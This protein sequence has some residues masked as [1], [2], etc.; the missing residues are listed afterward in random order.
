MLKHINCLEQCLRLI[1]IIF[2]FV[3]LLIGLQVYVLSFLP[4]EWIH[5]NLK[6]VLKS[7]NM[8][9]FPILMING[10][11]GVFG[12]LFRNTA[13][14][15][16]YMT[17]SLFSA[18]LHLRIFIFDYETNELNDLTTSVSILSLVTIGVCA[19]GFIN[20][21]MVLISIFRENRKNEL[22][23]EISSLGKMSSSECYS[24]S[25][26]EMN[27]PDENEDDDVDIY[28]ARPVSYDAIYPKILSNRDTATYFKK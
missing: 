23:S 24:K 25:I 10:S 22:K 28:N 7:M 27:N 19:I 13:L 6:N 26:I 5:G 1:F 18:L 8:A 21:I 11:I 20:S 9:I 4:N 15:V 12:V 3:I 16:I 17:T 2:N 14:M